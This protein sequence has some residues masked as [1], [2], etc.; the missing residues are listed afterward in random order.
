MFA[1]DLRDGTFAVLRD[2]GYKMSPTAH[3]LMWFLLW[4][5]I[6]DRNSKWFGHVNINVSGQRELAVATGRDRKAVGMGLAELETN[7][8]I[9]RYKRYHPE[10]GNRMP[11]GVELTSPDDFCMECRSRGHG[12]SDCPEATAD[13]RP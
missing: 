7:G 10:T 12:E 9:K 3:A 11:D 1:F 5:G 6:Y 2:G 13:N 8:F 4:H